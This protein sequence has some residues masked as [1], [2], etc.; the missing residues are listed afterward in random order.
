MKTLLFRSTIILCALL[1][2]VSGQA[3]K[4]GTPA[5]GQEPFDILVK[6]GRI[7]DGSGNPWYGADVGIRGD[8]IAAIGRLHD[9][10][11]KRVIDASGL[12]LTPRLPPRSTLSHSTSLIASS[13]VS[14]LA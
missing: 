11:A 6:N 10:K 7:I 9:A 3:P 8:R 5:S 4:S 1:G 13:E 14:K 12:V 2:Q